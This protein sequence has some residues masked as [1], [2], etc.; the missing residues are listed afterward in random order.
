MELDPSTGRVVIVGAGHAGGA[1]ALALRKL[2][3]AGTVTVV[4]E[5]TERPYERPALSKSMLVD[6]AAQPTFLA[7]ASRWN[8]IDLRL[9]TLGTGIDRVARTV[10]TSDGSR[11]P[12]DA[13]VLATGGR[14]RLPSFPVCAAIHTL[15]T[16]ADARRLRAAAATARTAVVIG[17]G[18]VGLEVAASLRSRGLR[19]DVLEAAPRL[20]GR[21]VPPH[22]ASWLASLHAAH[23]VDV[24]LGQRV[25]AVS[26]AATAGA[27]VQMQ[28]GRSL[29][30]DLVVVGI[31]ILPRTEL[32]E[33]AGL[34][35]RDGVLVDGCYR[36]VAD[37]AVLAIGDAAAW[38]GPD[39]PV[40]EETW[41]HAQRSAGIA[42]RA[43]LGLPPAAAE[44]PWFWTDQYGH[45]LQVAGTPAAADEVLG[46]GA[47]ACLYLREGALVGV[48]CLDAPRVFAAARRLIASGARLDRA[49]AANTDIDLRKAVAA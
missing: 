37:P 23:G 24:H 22:A 14:A 8:G 29:P 35:C 28:D 9:E 20:L 18:V 47:T 33:A 16:A 49:N 30:C 25:A 44:V 38:P 2:G 11:L 46:R 40:R 21:N 31:G 34:P 17:G 41:D 42:A 5:E 6:H 3:F 45:T 39:G 19:V 27:C 26:D 1:F 12:Y 10:G 32:A 4:G 7:D 13:L 15:R 48:A 36:S 43:L